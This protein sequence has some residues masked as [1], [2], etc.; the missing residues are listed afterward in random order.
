MLTRSQAQRGG[1]SGRMMTCL[2][3]ELLKPRLAA[4]G[5]SS[6]SSIMKVLTSANFVPV[7]LSVDEW[8]EPRVC[9]R[10]NFSQTGKISTWWRPSTKPSDRSSRNESCPPNPCGAIPLV[11]N[12]PLLPPCPWSQS[13]LPGRLGKPSTLLTSLSQPVSLGPGVC[14]PEAYAGTTAAMVPPLA[15]PIPAVN[16][17][18][19]EGPLS[20][21]GTVLLLLDLLPLLLL[22]VDLCS[23]PPPPCAALCSCTTAKY[24]L[25][26]PVSTR[27]MLVMPDARSASRRL[28][29]KVGTGGRFISASLEL[30]VDELMPCDFISSASSKSLRRSSVRRARSWAS[31]SV[32]WIAAQ[33]SW[34][35]D[36]KSPA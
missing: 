27:S 19:K 33:W 2:K 25:L 36:L 32:A 5:W 20:G 6:F 34:T 9:S 12:F 21:A 29:S 16:T 30:M 7:R 1:V 14:P 23:S 3:W 8:V 24:A 28:S 15:L 26:S 18:E 22:L 11:A 31:T 35:K 13:E 17:G 4:I 10:L